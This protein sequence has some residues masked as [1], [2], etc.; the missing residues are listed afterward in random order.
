MSTRI[1]HRKKTDPSLPETSGWYQDLLKLQD[2]DTLPAGTR[3]TTRLAH[4]ARNGLQLAIITPHCL[5]EKGNRRS[6]SLPHIRG[7]RDV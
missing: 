4:R 6:E 2:Q 3:A 5:I 1:T 7:H